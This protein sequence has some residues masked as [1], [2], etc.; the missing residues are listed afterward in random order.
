[1]TE[2]LLRDGPVH[3]VPDSNKREVGQW[4]TLLTFFNANSSQTDQWNRA[5][6]SARVQ[7][8]RPTCW[9][10]PWKALSGGLLESPWDADH[11]TLEETFRRSGAQR[12]LH[13]SKIYRKKEAPQCLLVSWNANR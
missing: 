9:P 2:L 8:H 1:M 13:I 6:P 3:A 7:E 11:Q 5:T 4:W 10:S 12:S